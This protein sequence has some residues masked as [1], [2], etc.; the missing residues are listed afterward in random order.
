VFK[1]H[2]FLGLSVFLIFPFKRLEPIW[3]GYR[4]NQL[5]EAHLPAGV[6]PVDLHG[7]A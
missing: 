2:L 7:S 4:G 3:N 5:P 6:H 1:L